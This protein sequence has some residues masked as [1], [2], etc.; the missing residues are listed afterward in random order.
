VRAEGATLWLAERNTTPLFGAG[1]IDSISQAEIEQAAAQQPLEDP[2]VHGR[3]TGRFGWRGQSNR[4]SDFVR[5]ACAVELGL[6]VSSHAQAA[7]PLPGSK[8]MVSPARRD[9][10]D[11]DCD[12]LVAFVAG[13]PAPRPIISADPQQAALDKNGENLLQSVGCTVC[14]R[15]QLGQ[16]AGIYSDLL[17]HDMGGSLADPTPAARSL[18]AASGGAYYGSGPPP[19]ETPLVLQ[20]RQR[21][22]RT[23]PLWGVR[24][25]GPYL[26]DG[27]AKT[28]DDAIAQH[29]GEAASSIKRFSALPRPERERLVSFLMTLAAPEPAR[30]PRLVEV[31]VG[32]KQQ[33]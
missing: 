30:L 18:A 3:F 23:P 24:D 8:S 19:G 4:L 21:E 14:H 20:R 22:W 13:L 26:H 33:L 2:S 11:Q 31:A 29:G 12:D 32:L 7:D 9:L 6:Q 15:P 28:I 27:R 17:L 25:S 1:A 5:G 16:V 10:T